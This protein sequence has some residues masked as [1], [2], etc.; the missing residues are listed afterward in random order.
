MPS[1]TTKAWYLRDLSEALYLDDTGNV[2]VRTGFAGNIQISGNVVIPGSVEVSSTPENPV[3][4]HV[5]EVGTSGLCCAS[6]SRYTIWLSLSAS[7]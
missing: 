2:T 3:H 7:V 5:T 1:S 4:N 6:S